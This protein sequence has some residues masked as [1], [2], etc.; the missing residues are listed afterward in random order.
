LLTGLIPTIL[1][2]QAGAA[3]YCSGYESVLL[4]LASPASSS[5][6]GVT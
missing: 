3:R 6:R 5:A 4:T 2:E 1:P